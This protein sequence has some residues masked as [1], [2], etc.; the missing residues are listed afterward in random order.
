V[1]SHYYAIADAGGNI[2]P[3]TFSDTKLG[4]KCLH[5]SAGNR[6]WS[7]PIV[8]VDGEWEMEEDLFAFYSARGDH[9]VCCTV[10]TNETVKVTQ[11]EHTD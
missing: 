8:Q 5:V 11:H 3:G 10:E 7:I 4:A 1:T 2:Y 6:N 9:V